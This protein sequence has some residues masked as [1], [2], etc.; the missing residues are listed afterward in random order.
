MYFVFEAKID[1]F[2]LDVKLVLI[3]M[4][5]VNYLFIFLNCIDRKNLTNFFIFIDMVD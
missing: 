1:Y 2:V 4:N 5:Y 3:N